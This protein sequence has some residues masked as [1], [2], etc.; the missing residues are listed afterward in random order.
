VDTPVPI[1]PTALMQTIQRGEPTR[2][3]TWAHPQA[4]IW[5]EAWCRPCRNPLVAGDLSSDHGMLG[6]IREIRVLLE[7][8]DRFEDQ[9]RLLVADQVRHALRQPH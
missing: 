4:A 8:L 6:L 5:G 2:Q 3:G 7:A 9:D 1:P